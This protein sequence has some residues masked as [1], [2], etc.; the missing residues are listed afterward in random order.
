MSRAHR[1]FAALLA[2]GAIAFLL[3]ALSVADMFLPRPYDGVILEA[4]T[5]GSTVV[6]EVVEGSGADLAGIRQGD[7]IVGIDRSILSSAGH[8]QQLLNRHSIGDTVPYMF[9]SGGSTKE[10][11]VELGRRR[12]GDTSYLY[13]AILGF[14]FFGIGAFVVIRQPRLP[15]ARVFYIMCS[16]FMLFLVCRLR[17]ASYS[18]VDTF[19]L[20]TG[21]MAL[22]FLPAA[23]LHFFLI[24]P[25]PVWE[26]RRDPIADT[27]GWI[28][29]VSPRLVPIYL[30]HPWSTSRPSA[31][32]GGPAPRWR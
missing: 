2:P 30:L 31:A 1:Q 21:T 3:A 24:F 29:K 5:P 22:L 28:A 9:R 19:V 11:N 14:L 15:T 8:A 26:W 25:R 27:I 13:A 32:R 18:W 10:R 12:I 4:D 6:H 7:V 23:F 17:P 20:S 16:L